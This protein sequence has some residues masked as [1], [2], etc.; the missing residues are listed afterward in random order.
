MGMNNRKK[1][2]RLLV[3]FFVCI[4]LITI[5]QLIYIDYFNKLEHTASKDDSED[6]Y[7]DLHAR[8][9]NTSSWIKRD[10]NLYGCIVN[11]NAQIYDGVLVNASS[12]TIQSWSMRL[13]IN[14]DC[15]LNQFWNGDVEIHQSSGGAG[16]VVQKLN[17]ANYNL[18]EIELE[19]LYD[20][21]NLLIPLHKGDYIVFV[22]DGYK[23]L[24]E[25]IGDKTIECGM[26]FYYMDKM[27][28]SGDNVT[29]YLHRNFVGSIGF[30]IVMVMVGIFLVMFGGFLMMKGAYKNAEKEW[31]I[32]QSGIAS[33]SDIYSIIY[34][35]DLDKDELTPVYADEES[36]K[37]RPKDKGAREQLLYMTYSDAE[38]E[39]LKITQDF[40]DI[41]TVAER[42]E[43]G[44]IA[45][46]YISK[47]HGWTQI[48]FFP[49][50][51][52]EGEPVKKVIFA[53]QDI[54]E[55]K[56][57]LKRYEDQVE[58][59]KNARNTYLAGLSGR[60]GS[61]LSKIEELNAQILSQSKDERIKKSAE[62]IKSI[63]KIISYMIDGGNDASLLSMGTLESEEE[64]Y[65]TEDIIAEFTDIAVTMVDE[66]KVKL[67]RDIGPNIPKKLKGDVSRIKRVLIQLLSDAVH[68]TEKG[69]I[70]FAVYGKAVDNKMHLLLS[71]KDSG[72]GI[73]EERYQEL[74]SYIDRIA[75]HGPMGTVSNG[76]GLEVAACLLAFLGSKLNVIP[77][78]GVGTE[79]Y[80]EIDQV[81]IDS[82][83]IKG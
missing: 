68:Y 57:I 7:F 24:L 49:V 76:H 22:P 31:H 42:V 33:M 61:W 52:V 13:D 10:Y 48:R 56:V 12:D 63:G 16:K 38:E 3:I 26:I 43:K 58:I 4:I 71:I 51:R 55:E 19:Y 39:Y 66:A 60:T 23:T 70:R 65:N 29:Y 62:Q 9:D 44:S 18:D 17:L 78:S 50:D 74:Q 45:C 75:H 53:I 28:V 82:T 83:H 21:E 34:Y 41:A 11:L 32:K 20:G 81:I 80:F 54:N 25:I 36:E 46:E 47:S 6:I 8:N 73:T 2:V 15:Y 59:E 64:T 72:G 1:Y 67:E 79:F 69:S 37:Y 14:D 40:I 35:I 5:G 30:I 27:D 77:T